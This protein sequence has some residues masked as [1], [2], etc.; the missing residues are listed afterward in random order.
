MLTYGGAILG[1]KAGED[2]TGSDLGVVL[3]VR[4]TAVDGRMHARDEVVEGTET[5]VLHVLTF[6]LC[7]VQFV[8]ERKRKKKSPF[9]PGRHSGRAYKLYL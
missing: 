5:W 8:T 2:M 6:C 3:S 7:F 9:T 4:G 1:V